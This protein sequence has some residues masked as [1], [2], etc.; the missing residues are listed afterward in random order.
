MALRDFL[1]DFL[2]AP[3]FPSDL[4]PFVS[5]AEAADEAEG[6]GDN[7]PEVLIDDTY[8]IKIGRVE[9]DQPYVV[10]GDKK[11]LTVYP[12]AGDWDAGRAELRD[13]WEV[14]GRAFVG[15]AF[16]LY[17]SIQASKGQV[18]EVCEFFEPILTPTQHRMLREAFH[19]S[20]YFDQ[21][22]VSKEEEDKRRVDLAEDYEGYAMNLPSLCS[23]G[24]FG[25]EGLF[26]EIYRE[27][28]NNHGFSDEDYQQLFTNLVKN[29]PFVIFVNDTFTTGEVYDLII[30][31]SIH[32]DQLEVDVPIMH[33][34]G[35]GEYARKIVSEAIDYLEEEHTGVKCVRQ[36]RKVGA[37]RKELVCAIKNKTI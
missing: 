34:R 33:V 24:Y 22:N 18:E 27:S 1:S 4:N 28:T 7:N 5:A 12:K 29:R 31:K 2:G 37:S 21:F 10:D 8:T 15:T 16:D 23:A 30:T 9:A 20:I 25:E 19:T 14:S 26:R 36:L 13:L 17:L 35:I 3:D 6:G 32:L 11:T